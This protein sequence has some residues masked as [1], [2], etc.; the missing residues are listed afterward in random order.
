MKAKIVPSSFQWA[1]F[2][3]YQFHLSIASR[4]WRIDL[5]TQEAVMKEK[6]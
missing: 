2:P 4:F 1:L 5:E 3:I 6:C